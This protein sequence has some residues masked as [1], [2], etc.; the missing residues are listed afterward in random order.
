AQR[1]EVLAGLSRLAQ[2][3]VVD[4]GHVLDVCD[5]MAEE[6][7][8]PMQDVEAHVREGV[9]EMPGVAGRDAADVE[10]DGD[11]P[12]DRLERVQPAP[13]SVVQAKGHAANS[14][15]VPRIERRAG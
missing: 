2:D 4:I 11:P 7:E 14:K 12:G 5:V 8:I 3:V 9:P 1:A 13:A 10:A 15:A 6:L